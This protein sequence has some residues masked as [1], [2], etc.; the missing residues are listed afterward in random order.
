MTGI[1][2]DEMIDVVWFKFDSVALTFKLKL[3]VDI[4]MLG[5]WLRFMWVWYEKSVLL[6]AVVFVGQILS[7]F[8]KFSLNFT[9]LPESGRFVIVS[10]IDVI[11]MIGEIAFNGIQS[12]VSFKFMQSF[13]IDCVAETNGN[14]VGSLIVICW[15]RQLLSSWLNVCRTFG[16]R[17]NVNWSIIDTSVF[18]MSSVKFDEHSLGVSD[19][20]KMVGGVV[21]VST[22][23]SH[24]L[25]RGFCSTSTFF[26]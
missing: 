9:E 18:A 15:Y 12:R 16:I 23:N 20:D 13:R 22:L 21:V 25:N 8:K 26:K 6:A 2:A 3:S 5:N 10:S 19:G 11:S 4:R 14:G 17:L 1:D 24:E 7:E